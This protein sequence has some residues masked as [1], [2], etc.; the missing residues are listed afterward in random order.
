MILLILQFIG[1][2]VAIL[3]IAFVMSPWSIK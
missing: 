2:M 3:A 1:L